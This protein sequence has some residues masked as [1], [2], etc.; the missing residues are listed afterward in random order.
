MRTYSDRRRHWEAEQ[1]LHIVAQMVGEPEG[2]R[3][4]EIEASCRAMVTFV[5]CSSSPSERNRP[6]Q[7]VVRRLAVLVSAGSNPGRT[8]WPEGYTMLKQNCKTSLQS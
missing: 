3:R 1:G 7:S 6:R 4:G 2:N 8:G 5:S